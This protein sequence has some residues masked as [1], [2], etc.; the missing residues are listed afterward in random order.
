MLGSA[1][2][3]ILFFLL[4]VVGGPAMVKMDRDFCPRGGFELFNRPESDRIDFGN[5]NWLSRTVLPA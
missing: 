4:P 1:L 5:A 3:D 2:L